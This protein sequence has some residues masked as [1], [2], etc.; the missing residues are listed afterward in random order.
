MT[1]NRADL[2]ELVELA[3]RRCEAMLSDESLKASGL[4]AVASTLKIV[5]E[6]RREEDER[7]ETIRV[8]RRGSLRGGRRGA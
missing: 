3:A 5:R 2:D 1:T 8:P 4:A 7:T 6:H